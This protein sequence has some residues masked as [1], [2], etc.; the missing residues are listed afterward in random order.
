MKSVKIAFAL[1]FGSMMLVTTGCGKSK[2]LMSAEEYEKDACACKDTACATSATKK[3]GERAKDMAS[4]SSGEADA[5]TKATTAASECV[6]KIA[7]AGVPG[8]PGL[9]TKK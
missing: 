2:A 3:F 7:M 5:I 8:M 9:P 1:C 6:T 4:A